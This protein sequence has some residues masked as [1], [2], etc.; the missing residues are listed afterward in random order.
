MSRTSA[1]LLIGCLLTSGLAACKQA[2][3]CNDYGYDEGERFLFTVTGPISHGSPCGVRPL[4]QGES[5]ILTAGARV[6]GRNAE[7]CLVP[8]SAQ[9]IPAEPFAE[10]L[11]SCEPGPGALGLRCTG[12]AVYGCSMVL[13]LALVGPRRIRQTDTTLVGD[14]LLVEWI[15]SCIPGGACIENYPVRVERL[16]KVDGGT[17][18]DTAGGDASVEKTGA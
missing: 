12:G 3:E 14:E 10:T 7:G 13:E 4:V 2:A 18:L 8:A 11:P 5:L 16:G 1:R 6:M 15:G 9:A 17:S